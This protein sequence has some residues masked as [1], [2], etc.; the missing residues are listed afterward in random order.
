MQSLI[1]ISE[2]FR[3]NANVTLFHECSIACRPGRSYSLCLEIRNFVSFNGP[4]ICT[5]NTLQFLRIS[6]GLSLNGMNSPAPSAASRF[7]KVLHFIDKILSAESVEAMG[8]MPE[9]DKY[10]CLCEECYKRTHGHLQF[11]PASRTAERRRKCLLPGVGKRR[12]WNPTR[13]HF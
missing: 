7:P 8:D 2:L 9:E 5:K 4:H 1:L 10:T 3:Q 12:G 13:M 6:P 11:K